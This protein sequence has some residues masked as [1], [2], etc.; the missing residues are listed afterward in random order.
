[1]RL[2]ARHADAC[3]LVGDPATVAHKLSVLREHCGFEGRD[4][5]TIEV[6]HFAPARVVDAGGTRSSAET[7][8]AEEHIGRYR[9]LAEA[10]VQTAIVALGDLQDDASVKRFAEVIAAFR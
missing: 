4:P 7:G 9:E 10:G 2:V 1:L 3:N 5:A 6:T 8:T